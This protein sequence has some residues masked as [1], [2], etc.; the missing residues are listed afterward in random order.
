[1]G[2][3]P[4]VSNMRHLIAKKIVHNQREPKFYDGLETSHERENLFCLGKKLGI[5]GSKL[6]EGRISVEYKEDNFNIFVFWK[7]IVLPHVVSPY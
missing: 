6:K 7:C 2:N 4:N 3:G 1:M 5:M